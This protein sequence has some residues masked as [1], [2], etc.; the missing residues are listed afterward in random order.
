MSFVSFASKNES[1]ATHFSSQVREFTADTKDKPVL[2][3]KEAVTFIVRMVCSELVEL[4]QTV[5]DSNEEAV[6][7][8]RSSVN[9]DLNPNYKKPQDEIS[10]IADQADALADV[11]YY[12]YNCACKHGINLSRILDVVHQ[13]NMSK[14]FPDG[15]FHRR[16]DGKIIKPDG[17]EEPDIPAEI[18]RQIENGSW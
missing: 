16:D 8:V 14:K 18:K 9:T 2:M 7:L 5:T 4:A 6:E 12:V 13:A 15:T 17:W 1:H 11:N 10:L 3:S